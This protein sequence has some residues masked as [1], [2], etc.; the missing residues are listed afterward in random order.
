MKWWDDYPYITGASFLHSRQY[1]SVDL[2]LGANVDFDHGYPW[3]SDART[4][5]K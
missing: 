4:A 1:G 3:R 5:G 2:V